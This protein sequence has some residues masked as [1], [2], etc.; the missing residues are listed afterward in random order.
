VIPGVDGLYN[1][2]KLMGE[3]LC[4]THPNHKVRVVRLSNVCGVGQSQNFLALLI[5]ELFRTGELVIQEAPDSSKD[6]IALSDVLPA[7]ENIALS[8]HERTYNLGSGIATSHAELGE[9]LTAL[10]GG[11]VRFADQAPCRIFPAIDISR[12]KNEFGF[13]A[14][15]LDEFLPEIVAASRLTAIA[16]G[17]KS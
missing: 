3:S 9:K 7:L 2:S 13:V 14:S 12:I 5:D 4:V 17:Y 16:T 1:I 10:T 11:R 15:E 6:Y 8:G